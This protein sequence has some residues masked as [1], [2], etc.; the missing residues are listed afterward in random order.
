MKIVIMTYFSE[1][2][3]CI[4]FWTDGYRKEDFA[5]EFFW[6]H[7][8]ER[9]SNFLMWRSPPVN[10]ADRNRVALHDAE[11]DYERTWGLYAEYN[12]KKRCPLCE[13]D[14]PLN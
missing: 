11:G 9:I 12:D 13:I 1:H 5:E 6:E 10:D 14:L 3:P 7:S 4:D 8:D 2:G